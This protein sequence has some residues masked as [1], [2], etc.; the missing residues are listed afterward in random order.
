MLR[1]DSRQVFVYF[2]PSK[3]FDGNLIAQAVNKQILRQM[4]ERISR[5][6]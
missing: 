6:Y 3:R 4:P 5:S 2:G 1:E